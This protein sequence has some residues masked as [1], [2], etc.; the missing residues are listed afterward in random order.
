MYF[1]S[2]ILQLIFTT[3]VGRITYRL[4]CKRIHLLE[5]TLLKKK[6]PI[7]KLSDTKPILAKLE[8]LSNIIVSDSNQIKASQI[9]E[10]IDYLVSLRKKNQIEKNHMYK[11]LRSLQDKHIGLKSELQ[12]S[13][14]YTSQLRE[15]IESLQKKFIIS[16]QTH[17]QK[18]IDLKRDCLESIYKIKQN[19]NEQLQNKKGDIESEFCWVEGK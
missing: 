12:E 9:G 17:C 1:C 11:R 5:K 2:W 16:K 4:L 15:E 19:Y 14:E 13:R 3:I 7:Y 6:R 8:L 10:H 18:V